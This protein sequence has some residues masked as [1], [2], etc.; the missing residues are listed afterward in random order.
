MIKNKKLQVNKG[1]GVLEMLKM[2]QETKKYTD[3]IFK[4]HIDHY[5]ETPE[6]AYRIEAIFRKDWFKII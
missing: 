5:I 2:R 6:I 4:P 1:H 3:K